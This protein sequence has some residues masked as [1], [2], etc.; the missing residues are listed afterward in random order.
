MAGVWLPVYVSMSV[1]NQMSDW[2]VIFQTANAPGISGT[3]NARQTVCWPGLT[4]QL[5]P[6]PPG[7]KQIQLPGIRQPEG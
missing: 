6:V 3:G 2:Q 5:S 1:H 4:H 7:L